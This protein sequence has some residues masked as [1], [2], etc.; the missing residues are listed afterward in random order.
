MTTLTS[1]SRQTIPFRQACT[2]LLTKKLLRQPFLDWDNLKALSEKSESFQSVVKIG[3][4]HLMDANFTLGQ[5]FSGYVSQ[6]I[7]A[8]KHPKH[9]RPFI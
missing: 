6:L 7:M 4:T 3:R 1:R 5:E 8:S 2:L 9:P